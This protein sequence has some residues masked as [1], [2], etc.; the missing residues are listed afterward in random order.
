MLVEHLDSPPYHRP[1]PVRRVLAL[2][3]SGGIGLLTGVLVAIVVAFAL[4]WAVITLTNLL[5]R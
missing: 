1:G 4:A 2:A 5:T 3:A